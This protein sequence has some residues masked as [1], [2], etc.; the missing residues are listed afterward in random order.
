MPGSAGRRLRD[1]RVC[2][3]WMDDDVAFGAITRR[4]MSATVMPRRVRLATA[5]ARSGSRPGRSARTSGA[6]V[7]ARRP[8]RPVRPGPRIGDRRVEV[9]G[10][11][12]EVVDGTGVGHRPRRVVHEFEADE[13]SSGSW[14]M[15]RLRTGCPGRT[16]LGVAECCVEGERAIQIGHTEPRW[17]MRM[18]ASLRPDRR[19]LSHRRSPTD[20]RHP[21][22]PIPPGHTEESGLRQLPSTVR[23]T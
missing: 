16:E 14:S 22:Y 10:L 2:G 18:R 17:S 3:L 8:V 4:P 6:P 13:R 21:P 5:R 9:V 19:D 23:R 11:D 12:D 15:V 7:P 20:A 1:T